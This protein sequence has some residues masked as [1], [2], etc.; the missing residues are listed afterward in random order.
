ME[1]E[2]KEIGRENGALSITDYEKSRLMAVLEG[3]SARIIFGFTTGAFLTGFLKYM[4]AEDKL[5][6]QIAAIPVLAGVIQFISPIFLEKLNRRKPL[7]TCL[8]TLHRL[9]LVLMVFIPLLPLPMTDRLYLVAAMYLLSYLLLNIVAPASTT[10]IISLVPQGMRG[11]YFSTREIYLIFISSVMNIMMG[12]VVDH[13][14]MTGNAYGGYTVMY[15][16]AFMAMIMNLISFLK[17]K[18]PPLPSSQKLSLKKMFVM[19]FKEPRF[20]KIIFLFLI[21]GL[22]VNFSSPFFSVYMVSQLRLSYTFITICGCVNAVSYVAAV[23]MWGRIADKKSFTYSAMLSIALLGLTH[24][25]WFF[26]GNGI[27][28]TGAIVITLHILSG[29][30]W[31]GVNISLLNIPYEYTPDEGRT[32]YLGFNAA[33]SGL[34]GFLS[35]MLASWIVGAMDK[36]RAD[37][38]GMEMTQFQIIFAISGVLIMVAALYIR[39]VILKPVKHNKLEKSR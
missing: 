17:M 10:L 24:F 22:S 29:I 20:K 36:Y 4:G 28:L 14:E 11:K 5:C 31:G 32:V 13:F 27:A 37:M 21:W 2:N 1:Q 19:P 12:R 7:V 25:L 16:V 33:I 9:L 35:S 30:S 6:G 34:V 3:I 39:N 15:G 38:F 23:R 26:A 8:N 18:E